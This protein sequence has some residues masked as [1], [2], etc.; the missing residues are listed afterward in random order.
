MLV[1]V[2]GVWMGVSY[3]PKEQVTV[4]K[5]TNKQTTKKPTH[6]MAHLVFPDTRANALTPFR[7]KNLS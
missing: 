2:G 4:K 7:P 1:G 5:L 3:Y 6:K